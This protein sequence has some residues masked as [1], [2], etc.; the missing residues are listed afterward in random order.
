MS[1]LKFVVCIHVIRKLACSPAVLQ[2]LCVDT[3]GAE[4]AECGVFVVD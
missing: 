3:C 2:A 1:L 4:G